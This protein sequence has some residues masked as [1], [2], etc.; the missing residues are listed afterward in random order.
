VCSYYVNEACQVQDEFGT[1]SYITVC[2]IFVT[3]VHSAL[4][5]SLCQTHGW[6]LSSLF[7]S[8]T[9]LCGTSSSFSSNAS[10]VN[11]FRIVQNMFRIVQ[12]C[13]PVQN[14]LCSCVLLSIVEIVQNS[15]LV[16]NW[17]RIVQNSEQVQNCLCIVLLDKLV[18]NVQNSELVQNCS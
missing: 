10:G 12:N 17:F 2:I 6:P 8:A 5:L 13:K 16:Q 11:M 1:N 9:A 14:Y 18:Q 3:L 7:F 4:V 15:E